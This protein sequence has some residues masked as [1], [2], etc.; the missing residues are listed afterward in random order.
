MSAC[1]GVFLSKLLCSFILVDANIST[2]PQICSPPCCRV[3]SETDLLPTRALKKI[4]CPPLIKL[5]YFKGGKIS[6]Q[7]VVFLP[8]KKFSKNFRHPLFSPKKVEFYWTCCVW[9]SCRAAS[10]HVPETDM[11]CFRRSKIMDWDNKEAQTSQFAF[12]VLAKPT[13]QTCKAHAVREQKT[14]SA[15]VSKTCEVSKDTHSFWPNLMLPH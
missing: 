4:E 1:C 10:W 9:P 2:L 12:E 13:L 8:S 3:A 14:V 11:V 7:K 5:L 15:R 6:W